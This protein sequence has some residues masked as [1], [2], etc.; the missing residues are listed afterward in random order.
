[1]GRVKKWELCIVCVFEQR[2]GGGVIGFHFKK[3]TQGAYTLRPKFSYFVVV[4]FCIHHPFL[5]KCLLRMQKRRKSNLIKFF[6]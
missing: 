3:Q 1:M 5:S 4:V 2:G 6:F